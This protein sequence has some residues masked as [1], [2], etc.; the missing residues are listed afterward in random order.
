MSATTDY[1]KLLAL[2]NGQFSDTVWIARVV[3]KPDPAG[4]GDRVCYVIQFDPMK[5]TAAP[6]KLKL[7]A[8]DISLSQDGESYRELLRNRI[9]DWLR[10][11]AGSH[12]SWPN[13]FRA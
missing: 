6:R 4:A 13:W 7:W 3:N 10:T 1:I 2:P 9:A 12:K 5:G 11:D 8:S